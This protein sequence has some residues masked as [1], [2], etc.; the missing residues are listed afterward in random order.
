[1]SPF[2]SKIKRGIAVTTVFIYTTVHYFVLTAVILA[3][4][5]ILGDVSVVIDDCCKNLSAFIWHTIKDVRLDVANPVTE[6][7]HGSVTIYL[8]PRILF[9]TIKMFSLWDL[10]VFKSGRK[11]SASYCV[12]CQ[13]KR[14]LFTLGR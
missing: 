12:T 13:V 1:M 6:A 10:S 2:Q 14:Y 4:Q 9:F 7:V 3:V 8:S 11:Y 5:V